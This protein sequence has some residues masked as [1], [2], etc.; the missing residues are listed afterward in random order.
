MEELWGFLKLYSPDSLAVKSFLTSGGPLL[1]LV[2]LYG[3][4]IFYM[5]DFYNLMKRKSTAETFA[6]LSVPCAIS[7]LGAAM[8]PLCVHVPAPERTGRF[9][10]ALESSELNRMLL[11]V[12]GIYIFLWGISLISQLEFFQRKTFLGKLFRERR[13][14][15]DV[16]RWVLFGI[17]DYLYAGMMIFFSLWRLIAGQSFFAR[18]NSLLLWIYLYAVYLLCCKII[19]LAVALLVRLYSVK[20]TV[21]RWREGK[22]P[23]AFLFRYF[24]FYQSAMVRNLMLFECGLLIPI[25]VAALSDT[26]GADPLEMVG[27][28]GFLWLAA[29]FVILFS[30]LPGMRA[31]EKFQFWGDSRRMKE[32]FCREYFAEEPLFQNDKYTV[33]RH[34]LVDELSPC[35]LYY[36]SALE[37]ISG[38][39]T[40]KKGSVR[41]IRFS[42]KSY[43]NISKEEAE[44]LAPVFEY[45]KKWQDNNIAQS[46]TM[47]KNDTQEQAKIYLQSLL[48]QGQNTP[49]INQPWWAKKV[50]EPGAPESAYGNLIKKLAII[51]VFIMMMM[52]SCLNFK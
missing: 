50:E 46:N 3:N 47:Q 32:L 2:L 26:E 39:V 49:S 38:W 10:E 25:T 19:L 24:L 17:P 52:S 30:A 44:C 45:A 8:L 21:F 42:D 12:A 36:W 18:G 16:I 22:N 40:D 37:S 11:L 29:I 6:I 41:T 51:V 14:K 28:L 34:F 5:V 33:T 9:A 7:F 31:L 20:I 23:S 27:I 1:W 43:C 4:A 48:S 35:T 13:R 15:R